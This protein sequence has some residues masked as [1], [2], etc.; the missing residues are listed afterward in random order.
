MGPKCGRDKSW[1][2]RPES[3][4]VRAW[5]LDLN[6]LRPHLAASGFA[7][8]RPSETPQALRRRARK[9]RWSG[10]RDLNPRLRPWQGRTLPLSYSR[11]AK[12]DYKQGCWSGQTSRPTAAFF[13]W[14][15]LGI[16]GRFVMPHPLRIVLGSHDLAIAHVNDAIAILGR[17]RIVGDHQYRLL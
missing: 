14:L 3:T 4:G 6:R 11:S 7:A 12:C 1:K 17:L 16:R 8:N 15:L 5:T 2:H 10:R 13:L 9:A